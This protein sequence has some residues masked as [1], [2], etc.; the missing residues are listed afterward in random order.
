MAEVPDFW[1]V[2]LYHPL[3]VHAPLALLVVGTLFRLAGQLA[4]R[5]GRLGFLLPAGRLMLALGAASAWVAIWTGTLADGQVG[6]TLCDP[7]VAKTHEQLAWAVALTFSVAV[8]VDYL[9]GKII[10]ATALSRTLAVFLAGAYLAGAGML[11]YGGHLGATL[12][13]QQA[14]AVYHPSESCAEFE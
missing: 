5:E 2:E 7:T 13:Y 10:T 3:S 4:G 12:V 8:L 1:R 9:A 6:R 11:V 14:A